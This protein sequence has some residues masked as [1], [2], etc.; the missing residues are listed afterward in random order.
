MKTILIIAALLTISS[1]V[2]AQSI[3]NAKSQTF[4]VL[5]NCGS[6]KKTIEKALKGVDGLDF[7]G[8]GPKSSFDLLYLLGRDIIFEFEE[9][10]MAQ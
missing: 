8:Q 3:P 4:I 6:C 10:D 7:A 2:S 9:D 5:G 1:T